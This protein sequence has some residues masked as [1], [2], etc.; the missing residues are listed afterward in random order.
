[1]SEHAYGNAIDISAFEVNGDWLEVGGHNGA[2]GNA[3]LAAV[4]KSACGPFTTV[5]GPGSDS[6]HA[7]HFHL[8][9]AVRGKSGHSLYCH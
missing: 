4:R 9:L 6:Y 8:D 5:L 3:F 2:A 1:M 7:T